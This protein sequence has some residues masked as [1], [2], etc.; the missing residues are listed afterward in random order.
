[1]ITLVHIKPESWILQRP[2]DFCD[3]TFAKIPFLNMH[4]AFDVNL[5]M[6]LLMG[7]WSM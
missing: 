4:K 3:F 6:H 7:Y 5:S 1:L 2:C